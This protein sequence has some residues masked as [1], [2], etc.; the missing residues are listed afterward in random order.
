[1]SEPARTALVPPAGAHGG[2]ANSRHCSSLCLWPGFGGWRDDRVGTRR[3]PDGLGARARALHRHRAGPREAPGALPQG[4][5][6]AGGAAQD[7]G[8]AAPEPAHVQ[9]SLPFPHLA[10]SP[11]SSQPDPILAL[12][13]PRFIRRTNQKLR[14]LAGGGEK[15]SA[16]SGDLGDTLS[17]GTGLSNT[18]TALTPIDSGSSEDTDNLPTSGGG[19]GECHHQDVPPLSVVGRGAPI[20]DERTVPLS[21]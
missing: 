8:L 5:R 17:V 18:A 16:A 12:S 15:K 9:A 1:M 2:S 11:R 21:R 19:G 6:N 4:A 3:S 14:S 20:T 13:G 7:D 10:L